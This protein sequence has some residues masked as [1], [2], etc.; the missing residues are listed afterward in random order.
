[1]SSPGVSSTPPRVVLASWV[2]IAILG[3]TIIACTIVA[4]LYAPVSAIDL[5]IGG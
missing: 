1:M 4:S 5:A 2:V 3:A